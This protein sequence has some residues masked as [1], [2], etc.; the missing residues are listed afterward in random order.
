MACRAALSV[1]PCAGARHGLDGAGD[2]V[3]A[4]QHAVAAGE[5]ERLDD[6][7]LLAAAHHGHLGAG[8]DVAAGLDDA[9]VAER[10][11]DA[12]VGAEQAAL[13]ERDHLRCRRPR[14]CP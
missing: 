13:A 10:D 14:G 11:A 7:R 1:M 5:L 4:E 12:G 8:G 9:V 3:A 6:G 2:R